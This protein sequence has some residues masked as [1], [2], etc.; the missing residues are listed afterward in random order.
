MLTEDELLFVDYWEKN[1]VKESKLFYQV[2]RGIP[3]GLL[4]SLPVLL[5]LF[6]GRFW[7]KRA[8]IQMQTRL[9]PAILVIAIFLITLFFA[10]FYRRFQWDRKEQ[11]YKE[12]KAKAAAGGTHKK[13]HSSEG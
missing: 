1:R 12:L 4:F 11:Q 3:L 8:D 9:S 7:Y 2:L 6:S 13:Q 10:V 5:M